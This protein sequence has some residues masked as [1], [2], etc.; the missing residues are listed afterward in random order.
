MLYVRDPLQAAS[1]KRADMAK[2]G[3]GDVEDHTSHR[4]EVGA[5]VWWTPGSL[6]DLQNGE[7]SELGMRSCLEG[8]I[9]LDSGIL[10]STETPFLVISVRFYSS[11]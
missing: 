2:S 9:H 1:D 7:Q 8:E 5:A 11:L 3:V 10:P 4:N 6:G